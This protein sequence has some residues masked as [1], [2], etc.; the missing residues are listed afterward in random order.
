MVLRDQLK[1][2]ARKIIESKPGSKT[3]RWSVRSRKAQ[4]IKFNDDGIDRQVD[5]DQLPKDRL[6]V[7]EYSS[8]RT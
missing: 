4:T 6:F 1:N 3:L 2:V 5:L 7:L 8:A